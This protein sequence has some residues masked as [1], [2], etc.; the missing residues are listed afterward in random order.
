M[1]HLWNFMTDFENESLWFQSM[2]AEIIEMDWSVFLEKD[3]PKLIE[4]CE[5]YN[6]DLQKRME[7]MSRME[8]RKM[9]FE[10]EK[11]PAIERATELMSII[12]KQVVA[13]R[14]LIRCFNQHTMD[15]RY[16]GRLAVGGKPIR[17]PLD[18]MMIV[19]IR[20]FVEGTNVKILRTE[21]PLEWTIEG[22]GQTK[23]VPSVYVQLKN[24]KTRMK[25]AQNES[26]T[27]EEI[28]VEF[29]YSEPLNTSA[30]ETTDR[31]VEVTEELESEADSKNVEDSPGDE[32]SAEPAYFDYS[33][34]LDVISESVATER[35]IE[36]M[37]YSPPA[38]AVEQETVDIVVSSGSDRIIPIDWTDGSIEHFK[39][40]I[41]ECQKKINALEKSSITIQSLQLIREMTLKTYRMDQFWNF[42]IDEQNECIWFQGLRYD[43][44]EKDWL[45]LGKRTFHN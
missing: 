28:S 6:K 13:T 40:K 33:A 10:N 17:Q 36:E 7:N 16:T 27:N 2:K 22:N 5:K 1:D 45:D 39:R 30:G 26:S 8:L 14:K 31:F 24:A 3:A 37:P 4:D 25:T 12:T 19:S 44:V 11:H 41:S 23:R 29:D 35:R 32:S 20:G 38:Q 9:S 42:L 34:P 18:G 21:N 43:I 15:I